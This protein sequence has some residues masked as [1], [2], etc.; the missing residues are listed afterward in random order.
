ML[1]LELRRNVDLAKTNLV[2]RMFDAWGGIPVALLQQMNLRECLCGYIGLEDY[3]LYP[4]IRPG[5]FVEIDERQS[6]VKPGN[7]QNEF[8]RPIYFVELRNGYACS[9]C[10]LNGSQGH[11][12]CSPPFN[13]AGP[14]NRLSHFWGA[15]HLSPLPPVQQCRSPPARKRQTPS[16]F[17]SLTPSGVARACSPLSTRRFCDG[18]SARSKNQFS[19]RHSSRN[20]PLKLSI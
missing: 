19:F 1:P 14:L 4:L 7:W 5:S 15:L 10:E 6:R 18:A 20:L 8:D 3:T 16:A 11:Q 17:C 13:V 12:H 9:W 2:S